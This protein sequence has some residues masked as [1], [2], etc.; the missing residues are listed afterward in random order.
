MKVPFWV[1]AGLTVIF[2]V[3]CLFFPKSVQAIATR[4]LDV[5]AVPE[6]TKLRAYVRSD[7]Y[8]FNL[9]FI[10]VLSSVAG[11]FFL[12]AASKAR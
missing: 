12:Y 5:A 7:S 9:R 1:F 10:G 4:A 3:A 8:L 2:G 11:L 6:G